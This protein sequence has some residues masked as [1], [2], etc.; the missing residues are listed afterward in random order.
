MKTA[1]RDLASAAGDA[2]KAAAAGVPHG[3]P[4]GQAAPLSPEAAAGYL[5]YAGFWIRVC[6]AFIDVLIVG[7]VGRL[8]FGAE[9]AT[10]ILLI[11][12]QGILVGTWNGQTIGKRACGIK[13]ISAD[14][15]PCALGQAFGRALA[16]ILSVMTLMIGYLMIP[17]SK[18][19]RG[20][21]D[22]VAGTLAVYAIEPWRSADRAG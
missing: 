7:L 21:H 3:A 10:G 6:A 19:K 12:Y 17:L 4:V 16:K 11:L 9:P 8:F 20:L 18:Q 5:Y 14:G 13:I 15:R 2:L 22:H 1:I